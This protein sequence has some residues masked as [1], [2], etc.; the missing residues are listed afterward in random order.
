MSRNP[1]KSPLMGL[2]LAGLTALPASALDHNQ[3]GQWFQKVDAD[4]NG[5][6][7]LR[8]F[9]KKRGEQFATLDFDKN[10]TVT[11]TEY[12]NAETS[13]RRFLDLDRDGNSE[14]GFDEYL[15]PSRT[16]FQHMDDN[17]DGK[18]SVT[19]IDLFRERMRAQYRMRKRHAD[20]R[21]PSRLR[22]TKLARLDDKK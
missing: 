5:A 20:L 16:R 17:A 8:E 18:I 13:V 12:A 7:S 9:L 14:V 11:M 2:A 10:G 21:P 22:F 19:E 15:A 4:A 6:I 1:L 3:A